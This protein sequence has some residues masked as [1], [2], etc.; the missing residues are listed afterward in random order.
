MSALT[1]ATIIVEAGE[2]SGALI[3]ATA[4]LKQGEALVIHPNNCFHNPAL[5]WPHKFHAQGAIRVKNY[6]D[7]QKIMIHDN[8]KVNQIR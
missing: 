4:A 3:Q 5:T 8:T 6:E 1:L 2:T 7:I